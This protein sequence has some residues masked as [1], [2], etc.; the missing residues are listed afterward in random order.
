M[1]LPDN[2]STIMGSEEPPFPEIVELNVGGQ[3]YI[4]RYSTLLS[5]PDSLLSQMFRPKS[6]LG[7]AR[8]GKGRFFI[9]R[10]GFLFRYILDYMRDQQLVLPD[11]FPERSRLQ[12]EA[13]YFALPELVKTLSPKLSKQNSINDDTCPSDPED[14]SPSTDAIRSMVSASAMASGTGSDKRAGFIT[15]GY[16]GSY[17][18]GR[19]SQTD[20][21]FRR[22]ARIM[23]CGKTALAKEVFGETL[24][25][26]R[27][28]DRPPE[29]YTSRYYLKFTFLEQAFDRL[30]EAGF[31]MVSCNSTGTCAFAHDQT[32]DKIWTSYTE[33]IFYRSPN[34][35]SQKD[36]TN[37]LSRAVEETSPDLTIVTEEQ[38]EV[39]ETI[40]D[41]ENVI[42]CNDMSTSSMDC[43]FEAN[44]GSKVLNESSHEPSLQS[45]TQELDD[46]QEIL[47]D[48]DKI[49][50]DCHHSEEAEATLLD[51]TRATEEQ[52]IVIE[53]EKDTEDTINCN[54][55]VIS[56]S[57]SCSKVNSGLEVMNKN[58]HMPLQRATTLRLVDVQ[59]MEEDERNTGLEA[60]YKGL[61]EPLQ[62]ATT[63]KHDDVQRIQEDVMNTGSEA[64]TKS[65][66]EP[67]QRATTLELN[68]MQNTQESDDKTV[69][70]QDINK[71]GNIN[72]S[73][74]DKTTEHDQNKNN[75]EKQTLEA[76][77]QKCIDDLKKLKIPST[78]LKKQRHWQNELLKKYDM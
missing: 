32:D 73:S 10:D 67:P 1:A 23:V 59:R 68:D 20:A 14:G 28:P 16:R 63:L 58:L 12:R 57:E 13:E 19:D 31:H 76:E 25:E 22:V 45:Q 37:Q 9:D 6:G 69:Q 60:I 54:N 55:I 21:K 18:L 40:K 3:V 33:Y 61:Q 72:Q 2:A 7:L 56:S 41:A 77:L 43:C 27:D 42:S 50:M 4:T 35:W 48:E 75:D 74:L 66:Q 51:L 53:A 8:D 49:H 30:A 64:M 26:S 39:I 15:I 71:E 11:H 78:F 47:G 62:R 46:M 52:N 38:N 5:V 24:N 34:C 65:L 36:I 44:T 29:R 70:K 17:T